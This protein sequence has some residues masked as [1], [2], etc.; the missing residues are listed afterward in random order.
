MRCKDALRE[1]YALMLSLIMRVWLRCKVLAWGFVKNVLTAT[2][3]I[4]MY[5]SGCVFVC[6][7]VNSRLPALHLS[8]SKRKALE[9]L[10]FKLPLWTLK[11]IEAGQCKSICVHPLKSALSINMRQS[12]LSDNKYFFFCLPLKDYSSEISKRWHCFWYDE[13]EGKKYS[14]EQTAKK[15]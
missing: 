13:E 1:V 11:D 3:R 14:L 7:R 6:V 10:L 2:L 12:I 15:E 8:R 9:T 5:I 4:Y